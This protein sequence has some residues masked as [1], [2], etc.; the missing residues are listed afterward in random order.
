MSLESSEVV[1]GATGHIWR[2][3]VG[4]AFP[5]TIGTV[6]DE[7][8]WAELG[9]TSEDGVGFNLG[10]NV[11]EVMAWQA[12]DPLRIIVES[13]PK[14]ITYELLQL[15]Q[16][17][18]N[19]AMGGGTWTEP[20]AGNYLYVPPV[21]SFIDEFA[22]IVQ[23]E[24]GDNLYRFCFRKV[25]NQSGVEFS[26]SRSENIGLPVTVKVLGADAGAAPFDFQTN[27]ANLGEAVE[28]GS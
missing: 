10:R 11:N 27:D 8:L 28:A 18:W 22:M 23:F 6:V 3:A 17:T 9:Y 2:A 25:M 20:S 7:T 14:E 19:T 1:V 24:D 12:F 15:N 5:A 26:T 21:E 16:N 4:T 13:V